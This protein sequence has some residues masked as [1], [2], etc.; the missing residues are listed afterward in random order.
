[1]PVQARARAAVEF[2]DVANWSSPQAWPEV[3]AIAN[4]V[5]E[6]S[7]RPVGALSSYARDAGVRA[8][9][10]LLADGW[11]PAET[12]R[13]ARVAAGSAWWRGRRAGLSQLTAEVLRRAMPETPPAAAP[14]KAADPDANHRRLHA[15]RVE[16]RNRLT[17]W[18]KLERDKGI[19]EPPPPDE[20]RA[21]EQV[22]AGGAA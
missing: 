1:M 15:L 17:A 5:A 20:L 3:V 12:A 8:V 10:G 11:E 19:P 22:M 7:G 4:A 6:G 2:G 9:V 18:R 21:L 16:H 14:A 13:L